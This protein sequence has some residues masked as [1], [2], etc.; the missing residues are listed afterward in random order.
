MIKV[1]SEFAG[2]GNRSLNVEEEEEDKGDISEE[3]HDNEDELQAW[4]SLEERE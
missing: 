4:C 2:V 1:T 3:V